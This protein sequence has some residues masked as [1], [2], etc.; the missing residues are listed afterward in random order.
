MDRNLR[1]KVAKEL[2]EIAKLIEAGMAV[3]GPSRRQSKEILYNLRAKCGVPQNAP[4]KW[5]SYLSFVRQDE[6][7]DNS[8]YH[9]FAIFE[10]GHGTY[11]GGNAWGRIGTSYRPRAKCLVQGASSVDDAKRAM[12]AHYRKKINKGY[13][14]TKLQSGEEIVVRE[15]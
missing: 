11:C 1:L 15:R 14:P 9:F 7:N 8:K 2:L 4:L 5:R 10:D 13:E 3:V 6:M 12:M